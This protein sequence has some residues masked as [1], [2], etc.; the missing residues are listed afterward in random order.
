VKNKILI[1]LVVIFPLRFNLFD[2]YSVPHDFAAVFV[3][4]DQL[5]IARAEVRFAGGPHVTPGER[6]QHFNTTT[7]VL[8]QHF[9]M[10]VTRK[11]VPE[12]GSAPIFSAFGRHNQR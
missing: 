4:H 6:T 9:V 8:F 10:T 12:L 1:G 7:A 5:H 3:E 2:P 11:P